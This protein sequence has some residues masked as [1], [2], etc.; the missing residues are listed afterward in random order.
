MP[1]AKKDVCFAFVSRQDVPELG[2]FGQP[3]PM[4]LDRGI[5]TIANGNHIAWDG[6][7]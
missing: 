4:Q 5:V 6:Y 1:V 2:G 3:G 7:F